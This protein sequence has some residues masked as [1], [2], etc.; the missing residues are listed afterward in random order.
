M[1]YALKYTNNIFKCFKYVKYEFC[2]RFWSRYCQLIR[3]R[4]R[5]RRIKKRRWN[6]LKL[7]KYIWHIQ[8]FGIIKYLTQSNIQILVKFKF[9]NIWHIQMFTY[10]TH[11]NILI[12]D[13]YNQ[14]DIWHVQIFRYLLHSNI[15][16]IQ[17]LKYLS[18]RWRR[19]G[20]R[21]NISTPCNHSWTTARLAGT[22]LQI[23]KNTN[24]QKHKFTNIQTYKYTN[25][26]KTQMHKYT[27]IWTLN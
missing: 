19:W 1:K 13:T 17:T 6:L 15:C 20:R 21:L 11:S 7:K 12:F 24:T 2:N 26:Q 14:S 4:R 27:N 22:N 23:Y 8:I 10:L 5:R 3:Q 16:Y 25:I 18:S 9:S